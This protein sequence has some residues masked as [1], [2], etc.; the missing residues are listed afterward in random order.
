ML[1][2]A[3]ET[4]NDVIASAEKL[5]GLG[6]RARSLLEECVQLQSITRSKL[7]ADIQKLNDAGYVFVREYRDSWKTELTITPTIMGEE[8]LE[9]LENMGPKSKPLRP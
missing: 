6:S 5:K 8:A 3:H 9:Y 4:E 7:T 1:L 2:L